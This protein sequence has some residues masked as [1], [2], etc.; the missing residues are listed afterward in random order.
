MNFSDNIS[1]AY[2]ASNVLTDGNLGPSTLEDNP[3]PP[4]TPSS[5]PFSPEIQQML[6]PE[7]LQAISGPPGLPSRDPYLLKARAFY[8]A[9]LANNST[10]SC[11]IVFISS[12]ERCYV[13]LC[14]W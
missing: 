10:I 1:N 6:S 3:T 5:N 8:I 14:C 13:W 4:P 7:I 9:S 2:T 12:L 11:S